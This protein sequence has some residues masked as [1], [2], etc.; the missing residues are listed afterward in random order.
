[1]PN[2]N[3]FEF[4]N[5]LMKTTSYKN[6]PIII[7]SGNSGQDFI[8]KAKSFKVFDV[9]IKPVKPELLVSM[10]EKALAP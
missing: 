5:D 8:D 6:T 2:I 10:I 3:G 4:L 7:V 9:L 1:M